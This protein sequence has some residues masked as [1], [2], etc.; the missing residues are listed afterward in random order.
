MMSLLMPFMPCLTN[1]F[2]C[3]IPLNSALCYTTHTNFMALHYHDTRCK[4]PSLE[5]KWGQGTAGVKNTECLL[6]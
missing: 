3:A 5:T 4:S 2:R 1:G 6:P